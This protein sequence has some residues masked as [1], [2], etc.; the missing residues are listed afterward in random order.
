MGT[1]KLADIINK[2]YKGRNN[3]N[4]FLNVLLSYKLNRA[5]SN[6]VIRFSILLMIS[7]MGAHILH[8]S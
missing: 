1:C 2:E 5:E 8:I 7:V 3:M 6:N 4:F